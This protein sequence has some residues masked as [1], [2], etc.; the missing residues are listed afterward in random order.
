MINA[1]SDNPEAGPNGP[2]AAAT[3]L[4]TDDETAK[5][6]AEIGDLAVPLLLSFGATPAWSR[7]PSVA[8]G[9]PGTLAGVLQRAPNNPEVI[10]PFL[11][12]CFENVINIHLPGVLP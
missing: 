4:L 7:L 12:A 8:V 1:F 10:Y 6:C 9:P 5:K 3:T 2:L 11:R